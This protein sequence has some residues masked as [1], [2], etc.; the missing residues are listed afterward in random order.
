MFDNKNF[1]LVKTNKLFVGTDQKIKIKIS[2]TDLL[3][4]SEGS[5]I[6]NKDD[7]AQ[8][9]YLII[10]GEVKLEVPGIFKKPIN[11]TKTKDDFF[12]E[13]EYLENSTRQGNAVAASD[14]SLC[15]LSKE[16]I[17]AITGQHIRILNNLLRNEESTSDTEISFDL[18]DEVDENEDVFGGIIPGSEEKISDNKSTPLFEPD[19]IDNH[20][21]ED[22]SKIESDD[23]IPEIDFEIPDGFDESIEFNIDFD[24]ELSEMDDIL[25]I[26]DE[27]S[28]SEISDHDI[29]YSETD[30]ADELTSDD[31]DE[32]DIS[33]HTNE[34]EISYNEELQAD[35]DLLKSLNIFDEEEI[36]EV[37]EFD[38]DIPEIESDD[39]EYNPASKLFESEEYDDEK[40]DLTELSIK[41]VP[42]IETDASK[43]K[44]KSKKVEEPERKEDSEKVDFEADVFEKPAEENIISVK[45]SLPA[46]AEEKKEDTFTP[47]EIIP[48]DDYSEKIDTKKIEKAPEEKPAAD[49]IYDEKKARSK[50]SVKPEKELT[51]KEIPSDETEKS[52]QELLEILMNDPEAAETELVEIPEETAS[53]VNETQEEE[54]IGGI[55]INSDNEEEVDEMTA[56]QFKRLLEASQ[57]ISSSIK[58][59]ETLDAI[60]DA[61]KSLTDAENGILYIVDRDSNELWSKAVNGEVDIE[62]RIKIG[63]E[64]AGLAAQKNQI[65]NIPNAQKDT[66]FNK[67]R[68]KLNKSKTKSL[69]CFPV[70]NKSGYVTA[71]IQ[72]SNSGKGEFNSS[73]EEALSALSLNISL[74]LENAELIEK[75]LQNDRLSS[76]GKMA[77]FL[78]Q[79]IKKPVLT[80]KFYAEHIKKKEVPADVVQ[81]VNM[82]IDQSNSVVDL[83][84]TTL[85]YSEGKGILKA[86]PLRL[87]T[88]LN[89][90]FGLLAEYVESRN[91]KLFK[92]YEADAVVNIDKREFYQACFQIVKNACDAM[93]G[94]GDIY[95]LVVIEG[96]KIKIEFKDSGL[97]IPESIKGRIFEPFMTHGKKQGV[98]LGLSI[99]DKIVKDHGGTL[100]F[101]SEVGEG[102]TFKVLLPFISTV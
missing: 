88:V 81:I 20:L 42:P 1:A 28:E 40:E 48:V 17:E 27:T 14:C 13:L 36:E 58:L 31:N 79:D 96:D 102:T 3:T 69:L 85:S 101:E 19:E 35:L 60:V 66:R 76:L 23:E 49:K 5:T 16:K 93:P 4:F 65:I 29:F 53:Q 7:S 30:S 54:E 64:I 22:N 12:G 82:L 94:G 90:I 38:L 63:E 44:E 24:L 57:K 75:Q 83:V 95:V 41:D 80:I 33:V 92:K 32:A 62:T 56:A 86:Q 21:K 97:G 67:Q 47:D 70:T 74:A 91:V 51:K 84:Q 2:S 61:A 26:Q 68:D 59:D 6:Y 78:I 15:L 45:E 100:S 46:E 72:L 25:N 52:D 10:R 77:N 55:L 34:E 18:S 50:E 71:V 11:V 73:D 39:T 8:G 43:E 99:S 37:S 98:G 87:S 9:I 89:D